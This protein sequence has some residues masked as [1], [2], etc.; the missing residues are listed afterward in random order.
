LAYRLAS[1]AAKFKKRIVVESKRGSE[2]GGRP[3]EL[4]KAADERQLAASEALGHRRR[5]QKTKNFYVIDALN[6]YF[7]R[8]GLEEFCVLQE[9]VAPRRV[10]RFVAPAD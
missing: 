5:Y 1:E 3:S 9:E 4:L 6:A 10:H 2:N 8:L 7:K